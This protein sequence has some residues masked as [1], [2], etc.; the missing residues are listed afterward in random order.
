MIYIGIDGSI[1]NTAVTIFENEKYDFF[2]FPNINNMYTK[3]NLPTS[4]YKIYEELKSIVTVIEY[5]KKSLDLEYS[6]QQQYKL[7]KI[8]ELTDNII[9]I[10]PRNKEVMLAIEG[11]SYGS[12]GAA[13]IDLIMF[14]SILR[15]KINIIKGYKI[16]IF[17]PKSI[18][19][20][21]GNGNADKTFLLN[22]FKYEIGS[23]QNTNYFKYVI[24]T[25]EY[26]TGKHSNII[27]PITD[28]N[29]SYFI[30][31]YLEYLCKINNF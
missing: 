18:K 25:D 21:A 19:K 17:S 30:V 28:I 4:K 20:F 10:L 1:N 22:K 2:V 31:K 9:S 12:N 5:E 7:E 8:E 29:D 23:I 26:I 24:G 11:F 16:F 6:E 27:S 15:H 3:K 14:N 13:E